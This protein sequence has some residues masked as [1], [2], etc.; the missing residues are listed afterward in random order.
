MWKISKTKNITKLKNYK[1]YKTQKLKKMTKPKKKSECDKTKNQIVIKL[2]WLNCD[3]TQKLK[4]WQNS[5]TKIGRKKLKKSNGYKP[6]KLKTQIVT[7][8]KTWIGTK[9][10]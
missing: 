3:K 9:F 4:L 7:K 10:N 6:Q 1:Y 8:L 5:E 2:I